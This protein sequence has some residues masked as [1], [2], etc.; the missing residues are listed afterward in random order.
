MH[1]DFIDLIKADDHP[2]IAIRFHYNPYE[3]FEKNGQTGT[4]DSEIYITLAGEEKKYAIPGQIHLCQD[5]A[6]RINGNIKINLNDFHLKPPS[7]FMGMVKVNNEV[8]VNFGLKMEQNLIT[9]K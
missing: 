5:K 4:I 9:R 6:L 1:Q 7:K 2:Y 8:F 3:L